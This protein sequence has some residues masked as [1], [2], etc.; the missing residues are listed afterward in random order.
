MYFIKKRV[1]A[2]YIHGVDR[3][4]YTSAM[5]LLAPPPSTWKPELKG[6]DR[7]TGWIN[8]AGYK[9]DGSLKSKEEHR[10]VRIRVWKKDS[11]AAMKK[12]KKTRRK[13][14]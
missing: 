14:C 5:Y 8:A 3:T 12:T 1:F 2:T 13:N 7:T 4:P 11:M 10:S 6:E 9:K